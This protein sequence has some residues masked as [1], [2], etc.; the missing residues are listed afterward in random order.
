MF[1]IEHVVG[2]AF[3]LASLWPRRRKREDSFGA[4]V[5]APP[6]NDISYRRVAKAVRRF[7]FHRS[8]CPVS[9]RQRAKI[10]PS[11]KQAFAGSGRP[12]VLVSTR[13]LLKLLAHGSALK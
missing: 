2:E 9:G 1:P 5:V 8:S 13:R 11:E 7:S 4:L 12:L 6:L 3:S 10:D